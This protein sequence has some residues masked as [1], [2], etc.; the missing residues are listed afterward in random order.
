MVFQWIVLLC[1]KLKGKVMRF[2]KKCLSTQLDKLYG[3]DNYQAHIEVGREF[4]W[5]F[6]NENDIP[7][8][9]HKIRITYLR[10]GCAFYVIE[11]LPEIPEQYFS[12]N[13]LM[14]ATL[15]LAEIDPTRDLKNF[16]DSKQQKMYYFDPTYTIVNNWPNENEIEIDEGDE[17]YLLFLLCME[18]AQN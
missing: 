8:G 6:F 17:S 9:W 13:S 4:W 5:C 14:A 7:A 2:K 16:G 11:D 3:G 10:S 12:V 15:V 1:L 18:K